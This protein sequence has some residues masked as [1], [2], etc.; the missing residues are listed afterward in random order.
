MPKEK[1]KV[2]FVCLGN[3]CRSP[4]AEGVFRHYVRQAG[5]EAAFMIDSAGTASYH[6]GD[7]PDQRTAAVALARGIELSSAARQITAA[8]L[9]AFDYILAM[10]R[11]NLAN[12][13]KLLRGG[14]PH[15]EIRLLRSF[16]PEANGEHD[17]PDPYYGGQRG[18]EN[19]QDMVERACRELLRHIRAQHSL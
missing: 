1:L 10:D 2:L 8:D 3:I 7:A 19:V 9:D 5:L 11:E 18:F 15:A 12:V 17:V 6:V 14:Q 13:Q 16:D 4:L